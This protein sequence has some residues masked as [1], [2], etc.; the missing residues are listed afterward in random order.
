M[1]LE[2][3]VFL[4]PN[5]ALALLLAV[6]PICRCAGGL[7]GLCPAAL[8]CCGKGPLGCAGL[9]CGVAPNAAGLLTALPS[10]APSN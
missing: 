1:S 2:H 8:A 3:L 9:R 6:W 7:A 5:A 10:C 4:P